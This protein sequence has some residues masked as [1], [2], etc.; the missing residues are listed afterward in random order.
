MSVIPK[1]VLVY[2][3]I[4]SLKTTILLSLAF[5]A[6]NDGLVA[7][8]SSWLFVGKTQPRFASIIM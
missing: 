7:Y 5:V 6:T 2:A 3:G 1:C 4:L 8:L